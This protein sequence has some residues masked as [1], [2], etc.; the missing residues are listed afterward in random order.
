MNDLKYCDNS[1]LLQI[2]EKGSATPVRFN[3]YTSFAAY[4]PAVPGDGVV[5]HDYQAIA[6]AC[7]QH[8]AK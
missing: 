1:M 2:T 4:N 6:E 3:E 8:L 5:T 7:P